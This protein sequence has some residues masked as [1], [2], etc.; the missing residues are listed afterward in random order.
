MP[1]HPLR[2][3]GYVENQILQMIASGRLEAFD[4][5]AGRL[6]RWLLFVQ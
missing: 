2:S 6:C 4:Q 5:P 3:F 1:G